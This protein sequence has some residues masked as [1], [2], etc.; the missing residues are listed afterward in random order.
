[1]K[2]SSVKIDIL[3]LLMECFPYR[4]LTF[5]DAPF[6]NIYIRIGIDCINFDIKWETYLNK[7]KT[8]T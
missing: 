6:R 4:N 7:T 3:L 5:E 1:V 8:K 2:S